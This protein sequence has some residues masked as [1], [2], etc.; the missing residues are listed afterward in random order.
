MLFV[1]CH[2]KKGR[3]AA[4]GR[5]FLASNRSDETDRTFKMCACVWAA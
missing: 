4:I 1:A 3:S 2:V 5:L